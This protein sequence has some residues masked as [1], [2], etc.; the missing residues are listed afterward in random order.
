MIKKV[1]DNTRQNTID[2]PVSTE[3]LKK[4]DSQQEYVKPNNLMF[5]YQLDDQIGDTSISG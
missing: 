4:K 3:K 1:N 5:E 2:D